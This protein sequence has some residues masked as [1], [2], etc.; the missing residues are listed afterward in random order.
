[1][2]RSWQ[3]SGMITDCNG[4]IR[5]RRI[6][7]KTM[8]RPRKRKRA[9]PLPASAKRAITKLMRSSLKSPLTQAL[10][11]LSRNSE[12][13]RPKGSRWTP[14]AGRSAVTRIG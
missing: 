12:V 14:A 3:Q 5:P 6:V 4:I 9:I 10:A 7:K 11:T 2:A 8:V 13:G 1:M